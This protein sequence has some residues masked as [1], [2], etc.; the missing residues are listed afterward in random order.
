MTEMGVIEQQQQKF[1]VKELLL[2]FSLFLILTDSKAGVL[3]PNKSLQN[4]MSCQL[5][6][7]NE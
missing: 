5:K 4:F 1:D 7:G 6:I 3:L 2:L